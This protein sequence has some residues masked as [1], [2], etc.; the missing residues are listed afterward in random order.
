MKV[1]TLSEFEQEARELQFAV[2]VLQG[3]LDSTCNH[4]KGSDVRTDIA[5]RQR[6]L[7]IQ[8]DELDGKINR[9]SE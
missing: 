6:S 8:I 2:N 9:P 1:I 3:L 7:Q 4:C 5:A